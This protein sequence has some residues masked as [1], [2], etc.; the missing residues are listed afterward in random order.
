MKS[1]LKFALLVC[2]SGLV[3]AASALPAYAQGVASA[4]GSGAENAAPSTG[5]IIVTAQRRSERL[6][7]VPIAIT[8]ISAESATQL[9]LRNLRDLKLVVPNVDFGIT[10][11]FLALSMRGIGSPVANPGLEAPVSIYVDNV[12]LA[13]TGGLNQLL[14][15]VDAGTLEVLRG[16][17]GT[18]YGRN[19]TGGVLRI[20]SAQPTNNF[21]G[22]ILGEYGRFDHKQ[23][24]AMLNVPL[25][26]TLAVRFAGRYAKEDGYVTNIFNGNKLGA[27][28]NYTARARLKWDPSETVSVTGG[29]EWQ[30]SRARTFVGALAEGAPTCYVC[31]RS[32]VTVPGPFEA[33][34]DTDI[35]YY[36][37]M[38]RADLRINVEL[39]NFDLTSTTGYFNNFSRQLAEADTTPVAAFNFLV[40]GNGGK[41]YSQELQLAS[42]LDGPL[43]F[44]V[45][46]NYYVDKPYINIALAGSDYG[47][48]PLDEFTFR[49]S[50]S[51]KTTSKSAF[52]E[53]YYKFNDRIKATVGGRYTSDRRVLNVSNG[54]GFIGFGAAPSYTRSA[55]FNAFTPRFVLA[56]EN[57]DTNVYYSYTR[58]FK[59][60]GFNTPAP[61]PPAPIR[62]EK[63]FSHEIGVK[64]SAFDGKLR[65]SLAVF[66][67]KNKGLQQ[68][69]IDAQ[70]GGTSTTNAGSAEGYGVELELNATPMDGLNLGGSAAYLHATYS[71]YRNAS[72]ICFDP[73]GTSNPAAPG[74]T[75]YSCSTDLTGTTLPHA[76][77]FTASLNA[78]YTFAVADWTANLAGVMQYRSKFLFYP[79]ASGEAQFDKE[80]GYAVVNFSG[81]V[82]PPSMDKLRVGFYLDNAFNKD[83]AILKTTFQ[84]YAL[85]RDAAKP[86]TYGIRAEYSF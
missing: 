11:G 77:R 22:R 64:N 19:A 8:A 57:G 78:S 38:F 6:R 44:V 46:G 53:A 47:V 20:S 50:N 29:V 16:P 14:D 76:P 13:R 1:N 80:A 28:N 2:A 63:V 40:S 68:S 74:A 59:A 71:D 26:D 61:F 27:T 18:L 70:S 83:Y 79:G 39:G 32:P 4:E 23:L 49:N 41:S 42:N 3:F 75:L 51:V 67:Y 34:Q 60:G 17:Q 33:N 48:G 25:T 55:T 69:V 73:T 5:D 65:S 43:N 10:S 24:E 37:R 84:P 9:G 7:D 45:G 82:S 66:Y 86:R 12:Y 31:L 62:P 30:R 21:E 72:I 36:N 58:G 81:Y 35:P 85:I 54:P 15:V 56:W 52:L